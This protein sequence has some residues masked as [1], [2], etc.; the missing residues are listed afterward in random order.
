MHCMSAT[1]IQCTCLGI[2]MYYVHYTLRAVFIRMHRVFLALFLTVTVVI[3]ICVDISLYK[4]KKKSEQYQ[5]F[6]NSHP[7]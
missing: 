2:V 1:D 6:H 3:I 5:P 7:P 4:R